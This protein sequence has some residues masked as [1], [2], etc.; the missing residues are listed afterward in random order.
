MS[1][2]EQIESWISALSAGGLL[3]LR[4]LAARHESAKAAKNAQFDKED[5][6][7]TIKSD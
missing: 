1:R 5:K 3:E 6:T 7:D 2:E 4:R